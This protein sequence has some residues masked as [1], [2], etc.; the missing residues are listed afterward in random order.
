LVDSE[1]LVR[2]WGVR[3]SIACPGPQTVRYGGNTSCVEIRCG[4]HLIVFDGGTGLRP[5]GKTLIE[6]APARLRSVLHPHP[7]RSLPRSAVFRAMLR[8]AQSH[9]RLGRPFEARRRDQ[10]V[11]GKM[12]SAPLFDP[13]GHLQRRSGLTIFRRRGAEAARG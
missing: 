6:R 1:F 3:G 11:L 9:P 5:L 7:Y 10:A 4:E 13:D 12:M 8:R 2:F